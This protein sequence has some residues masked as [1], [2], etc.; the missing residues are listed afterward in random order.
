MDLHSRDVV[1]RL[2]NEKAG[3][4]NCFGWQSQLRLRWD[5]GVKECFA[6]ICDA[7]FRYNYE[8]LGNSPR[9]VITPL[10]ERCCILLA[11]PSV[12]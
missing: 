7:S 4:S 6:H 12:L 5:E 2:I 11:L 8:Y 3:N 10:I 1:A 9:L